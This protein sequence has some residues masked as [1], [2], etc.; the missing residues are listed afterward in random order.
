M[1]KFPLYGQ[2]WFFEC[3]VGVY[4]ASANVGVDGADWCNV[5]TRCAH[6]AYGSAGEF[7]STT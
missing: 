4:A 2:N 5:T 1:K 3:D 6:D 7:A